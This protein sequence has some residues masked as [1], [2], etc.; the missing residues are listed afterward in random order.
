MQRQSVDGL[1]MSANDSITDPTVKRLRRRH[2]RAK[3]PPS[4]SSSSASS[5]AA[6]RDGTGKTK[7]AVMLLNELQPAGLCYHG[8]T[9]SGPDHKPQYTA[10][11]TVY[12]QVGLNNFSTGVG[13]AITPD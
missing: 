13:I 2:G 9:K 6:A 12:G 11:I 7:N 3:Q 10:S 1:T 8:V 4:S 5:A